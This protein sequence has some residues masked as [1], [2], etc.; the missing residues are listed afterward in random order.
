MASLPA[1]TSP[2]KL[3]GSAKAAVLLV[4]IGLDRAAEVFRHLDSEEVETLSLEMAKLRAV[5]STTTETIV[6]EAVQTVVAERYVAEG[7]VSYA[8]DLLERSFGP[9]RASEIIGRLAAVIERRPFEFL[10][11]TP[12]EQLHAFLRNEAPQTIALV[13]ANLHTELAAQVL[14]EFPAEE[15]AEIAMRVATMGETAPEVVAAVEGVMKDKLSN[16]ISQEFTAAGGVKSLAEILNSTDRT[17]ERNVL[18]SMAE[19]DPALADE[20]RRLLFTFEDIR[21]LDDRSIQ[22]V[23]KEVDQK[24]LALALRG[25]AEDVKDKIFANLSERGAQMLKEEIDFQP[26]QR[27]NVVEEA[28][29]RIVDVIRRLEEGG[30]LTIARGG[31]ADD[32]LID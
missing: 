5:P 32:E 23:L 15:Q 26:A 10:R 14:A 19:T 28:Q 6:E 20:V 24:D 4:T 31:G 13:T 22:L 29:S 30:S 2:A 11:R 12:P 21:T 3:P 1:T 17:T 18:D 25:V 9:D 8:R 27:R 16:V 7:G